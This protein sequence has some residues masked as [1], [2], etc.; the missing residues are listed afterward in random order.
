M[1]HLGAH[2]DE[3]EPPVLLTVAQEGRGVGELKETLGR[4]LEHLAAKGLLARRRRRRLGDRMDALIR[5]RA[6][7]RYLARV[8]EA[9]REE[10]LSLVE[11]RRLTPVD[12][13]RILFD[14]AWPAGPGDVG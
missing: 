11:G 5:A 9:R 3:W 2:R 4:H 7:A 13:A 1:I 10:I 14:E 12:G 8:P 6:H